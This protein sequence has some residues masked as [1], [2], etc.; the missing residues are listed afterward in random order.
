VSHFPS[1]RVSDAGLAPGKTH[2]PLDCGRLAMALLLTPL[3]AGLYPA[4]LFAQPWA[5]PIGLAL[6]YVS[7]ILF[8]LP[9]ALLLH[10]CR[11]RRALAYILAGVLCSE[12]GL[13]LYAYLGTPRHFEPFNPLIALEWLIWGGIC[14]AVFWMFAVAGDS[15]LRWRHLFDLGPPDVQP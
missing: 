4:L 3:L 5:I 6:A 15:P 9:A 2:R 12:P 14:G 10:A 1:T 13:A 11:C 7:A 8:A